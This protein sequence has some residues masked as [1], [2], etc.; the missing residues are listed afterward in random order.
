MTAAI[1]ALAKKDLLILVRNRGALFFAFVWPTIIAVFF[2]LVFSGG[3]KGMDAIPVVV[4][5]EDGT[6]ASR[7]FLGVLTRSKELEVV[8]GTRDEAESLVRRGKKV[9]WIGLPKGFGAASDGLFSGRSTRIELGLDP[10]REAEAGFLEGVLMRH[11]MEGF[12][13]VFSDRDA[14]RRSIARARKTAEEGPADAPLRDPQL[15]FYGELD[16]YLEAVSA[17]TKTSTA[18]AEGGGFEP[19][20]IERHD[21]AVKKDGPRSYF[22]ISFPQGILWGILGCSAIFGVGLVRERT[23][24]TLLRLRTTPISKG[25][26]LAG[27]ALATFVGILVVEGTLLA[28]GALVFGVRPGS[29]PLVALAA[30]AS[31]VA[32]VGLAIGLAALAK[33][34]ESA[35]GVLWAANLVMAMLGGGAIPLMAMPA[36]MRSLSGA[37]PAKWVI[38]AL[39]GA[40]WRGFDLGELM[41]PVGVLL[42][43]GVVAFALGAR[44]FRT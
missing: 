1:F 2:G 17:Q 43:V 35:G 30:I 31:A 32:Y 38:L 21:V 28:F 11:G 41:V 34:E 44:A 12:T 26:V 37:S 8:T 39:E 4:V 23:I 3:S 5:D 36:W 14:S 6:D 42:A 40:I 20:R 15:R 27:R 29:W 18:K 16:G 10:S 9:A 19:V 33:T 22:D 25:T 7:A 13:S 24:G